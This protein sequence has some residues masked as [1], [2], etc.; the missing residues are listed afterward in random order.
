MLT[1]GIFYVCKTERL[2]LL[3]IGAGVGLLLSFALCGWF[4]R[5]LI[6]AILIVL[7]LLLLK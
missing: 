6:A 5:V 7:G 3:L 4:L 2:G 1:G